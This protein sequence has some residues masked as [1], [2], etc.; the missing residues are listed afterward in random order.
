MSLSSARWNQPI[1]WPGGDAVASVGGH[2]LDVDALGADL[3]VIG[4]QKALGGQA[5]VSAVS[6][7]SAAWDRVAPLGAAPSVL[8]LA[9][10]I[11]R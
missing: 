4:P 2:A 5:G 11:G 8:S 6:V 1:P 7:S 9:D 3:V 10:E